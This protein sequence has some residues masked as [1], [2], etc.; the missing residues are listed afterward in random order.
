MGVGDTAPLLALGHDWTTPPELSRGWPTVLLTRDVGSAQRISLSHLPVERMTYRL[1]PPTSRDASILLTLADIA[2]DTIVRV[3]RWEDQARVTPVGVTA[4]SA[5]V[6][7]CDTTDKPTFA[8]G[9]QIILWRDAHTFEVTTATAIAAGS[10]TAD[11]AA[12]W[13]PGTII[14]P[15]MPCRLVLPFA[16]THWAASTGALTLVVDFNVRDIAGVGT[17]GGG[18]VGVPATLNVTSVDVGHAGRGALAAIVTDAAGNLLVNQPIVWTSSDPT[19][20]PV[21][22]T[23]DPHIVIA[24]N[25][26]SIGGVGIGGSAT[27]TATLGALTGYGSVT[28]HG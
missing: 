17:G 13:A 2:I 26:N 20:V 19:N 14:A 16:L 15:V 8:V 28:L 21:Y 12:D 11:L 27:I 6:I 18:A 24:S 1:L 23:S 7:P 3:P 25:P 4:G 22:A 10:V 9:R 5:V